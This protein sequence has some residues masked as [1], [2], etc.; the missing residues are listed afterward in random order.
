MVCSSTHYSTHIH[1]RT[2]SYIHSHIRSH[3]RSHTRSRSRS[4]THSRTH[5]QVTGL[6]FRSVFEDIIVSGNVV[7]II[8]ISGGC[9]HYS[10]KQNV[11]GSTFLAG[12]TSLA[13]CFWQ[14]ARLSPPKA[15]LA[16]TACTTWICVTFLASL[17][18]PLA[19]DGECSTRMCSL[20][21]ALCLC[22]SSA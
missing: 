13:A 10:G 7:C 20:F 22:L 18:V 16:S 17:S 8:D 9:R 14:A 5:P 3:T 12:G 21:A 15:P 6:N 11:S 19:S 4:H 2:H 1:S